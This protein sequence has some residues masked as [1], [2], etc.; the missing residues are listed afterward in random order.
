VD[1]SGQYAFHSVSG[2]VTFLLRSEQGVESRGSTVSG[3]LLCD[4][5]H[6]FT[7]RTRGGWR[8][9]INGGGPPVRFKSISGD[10]EVLAV[11]D[12]NTRYQSDE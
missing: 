11:R 7:R 1:D 10:L 6:E 9:T 2:D 5:P 12:N 3:H 8:A 4:L